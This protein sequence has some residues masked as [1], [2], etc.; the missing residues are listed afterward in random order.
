MEILKL[1]MPEIREYIN[2]KDWKTIKSI[3]VEI[4]SYD[5]AEFLEDIPYPEKV[6]IFRLLAKEQ[7]NEVFSYIETEKQEEMLQYFNKEEIKSIINGL[8]PDDR[9]DLF[10]ELPAGLV[11]K[12]LKLLSPEERK[13]ADL[14]LNYPEHSAGHIMTTEYIEL[15]SDMTV[16]QAIRYLRANAK[17]SETIYISYVLGEQRELLGIVS[18]K[19]LMLAKDNSFI[20]EIMEENPIYVY[21]DDDQEVVADVIKKYDFIAVP[22]VDS[23]EHLVGIITFDDIIDV[24]EDEVTEDFQKMAAIT[25]TETPYFSTKVLTLARNRFIWI[26]ALIILQ[27]ISVNIIQ[28]YQYMLESIVVLSIFIP[29]VMGTGGNT[30]TQSSTIV[31]RG[32]A[33]GDINVEKIF[34][35]FL[36]ELLIGLLIAIGV[37]IVTYARSYF[38][39]VT[40]MVAFAVSIALML[41]VFISNLI[42]ALLP[43]LFKLIKIDPA[44]A[45]GPLVTTLTDITSLIIYFEIAKMILHI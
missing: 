34:S 37:G 36:K 21:T 30:G 17:E 32:L 3:I 44:I 5:I 1:I 35:L 42:G 13:S 15:Y 23:E 31:I 18:L 29:L 43:F 40:S 19:A 11:K 16:N 25:P 7:T 14:L 27:S 12:Y 4:E 6:I 20:K 28:G 45:A 39:H 33:T 10:D 41:T 9:N 26:F 22:V 38:F 24:L 8:D 2:Q